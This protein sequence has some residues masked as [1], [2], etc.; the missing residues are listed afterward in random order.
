MESRELF[1]LLHLLPFLLVSRV[2]SDK[3]APLSLSLFLPLLPA[4]SSCKWIQCSRSSTLAVLTPFWLEFK[5]RVFSRTPF[6]LLTQEKRGG[7]VVRE[8]GGADPPLSFIEELRHCSLCALQPPTP[9][10]E[11]SGPTDVSRSERTYKMAA[12][13]PSTGTTSSGA[14]RWNRSNTELYFP[15]L[16]SDSS[17]TILPH[18]NEILFSIRAPPRS[19]L[20]TFKSVQTLILPLL[21]IY[22]LF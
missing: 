3:K 7:V 11:P 6:P 13:T 19:H 22:L 5:R 4:F 1:L 2:G 21:F 16:R 20:I 15:G 10:P 8:G 9:A 12:L 18:Q 14:Q 17:L